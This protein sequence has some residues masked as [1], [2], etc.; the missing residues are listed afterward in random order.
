MLSC[1]QLL[2]N[3]NSGHMSNLAKLGKK[4]TLLPSQARAISMK[5]DLV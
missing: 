4:N 2:L 5:Q 1:G 3:P